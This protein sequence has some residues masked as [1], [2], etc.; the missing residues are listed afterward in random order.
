MFGGLKNKKFQET[1]IKKCF[2]NKIGNFSPFA[3]DARVT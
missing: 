2:K 3:R 1:K